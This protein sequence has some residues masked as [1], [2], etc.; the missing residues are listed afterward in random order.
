MTT[1]RKRRIAFILLAIT[2]LAAVPC[3]W[4]ASDTS[5]AS[6]L[7]AVASTLAGS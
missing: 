4:D 6:W 7:P 5:V 2:A 1:V 3:A